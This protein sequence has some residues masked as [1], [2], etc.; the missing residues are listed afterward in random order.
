MSSKLGLRV[1]H[2]SRKKKRYSK[3]RAGHDR[4]EHSTGHRF[5]VA[6]LGMA[7]DRIGGSRKENLFTGPT[8]LILALQRWV[9]NKA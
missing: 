9:L 2:E 7:R 3:Q 4:K 8:C 1:S 6:E 5:Q